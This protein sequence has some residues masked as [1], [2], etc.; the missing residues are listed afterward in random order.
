MFGQLFSYIGYSSG[1]ILRDYATHVRKRYVSPK[2]TNEKGGIGP[3]LRINLF[4]Q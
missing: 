4:I 1:I 2:Y 3:L